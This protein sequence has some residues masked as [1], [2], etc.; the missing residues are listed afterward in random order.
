[1]GLPTYIGAI[2]CFFGKSSTCLVANWRSACRSFSRVSEGW[3]IRNAS[4]RSFSINLHK[5]WEKVG[6]DNGKNVHSNR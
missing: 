5:N 3:I 6:G 2:G 1:M 4:L